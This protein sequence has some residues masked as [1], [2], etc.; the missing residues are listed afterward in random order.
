MLFCDQKLTV[1]NYVFLISLSRVYLC[2]VSVS[3]WFY[4]TVL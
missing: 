4:S 3:R 2:F 1:S